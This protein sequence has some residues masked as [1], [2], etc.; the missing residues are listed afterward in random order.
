MKLGFEFI[1]QIKDKCDNFSIFA[2]GVY[3]E[4]YAQGIDFQAYV[5]ILGVG[6]SGSLFLSSGQ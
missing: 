2:I 3:R 1:N 5:C 6:V 4:P